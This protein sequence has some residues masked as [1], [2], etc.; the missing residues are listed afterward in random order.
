M[1]S[2]HFQD[3]ARNVGFLISSIKGGSYLAIFLMCS[4][5]GYLFP[6]PEAVLLVL[7][8]F[9]AKTSP[10]I[11]I[12]AALAVAVVG[13]IIGDNILYRLS[14]F[15]NSYVERFN[16]K[17]RKHKL[18]K[19]E[20]LVA[21][22]IGATIYFLRFVVGVRFFGP[23]IAGT[24][25]VRWRKFFFHNVVA[26]IIHSSFFILLG[27]SW[28]GKIILLITEV[29]IVRN[30]LLFSSAVILGAIITIFMRSEKSASTD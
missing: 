22:N 10:A 1:I 17:M 26:N 20:H 11:N 19:Y 29:E 6:L 23:V 3:H 16:R 13:A 30:I 12:W 27:Y 4:L 21:D 15:G 7:V 8:G 14:F 5:V 28:H 2:P 9:V 25:G 18:I 24:L